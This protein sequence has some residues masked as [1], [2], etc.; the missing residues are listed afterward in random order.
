VQI[1]AAAVTSAVGTTFHQSQTSIQAVR[2]LGDAPCWGVQHSLEIFV[3]EPVCMH[4]CVRGNCT[5]TDTC[6]CE[7]GW[8]HSTVARDCAR[9]VCAA[10]PLPGCNDGCCNGGNCTAPSVCTCATGWSGAN[11]S[12]SVCEPLWDPAALANFD[13]E[14]GSACENGGVC[15]AHNTCNCSDAWSGAGCQI[16]VDECAETWLQTPPCSANSI[17]QDVLGSYSCT[18]REHFIGDGV[19]CHPEANFTVKIFSSKWDSV[20]IVPRVV[21]DVT[22]ALIIPNASVQVTG[23]TSSSAV[24]YVSMVF[25]LVPSEPWLTPSELTQRL[26]AAI[27]NSSAGVIG[28]NSLY[29]DRVYGVSVIASGASTTAMPHSIINLTL[30]AAWDP[31]LAIN[32]SAARVAFDIDF[33]TSM[34]KALAIDAERVHILSLMAGSIVV[35]WKIQESSAPAC[36]GAKM[37]TASALI[38]F[39]KLMSSCAVST[40]PVFGQYAAVSFTEQ[41]IVT[42]AE[43]TDGDT[44]SASPDIQCYSQEDARCNQTAACTTDADCVSLAGLADDASA[45][46]LNSFCEDGLGALKQGGQSAALLTAVPSVALLCTGC[47]LLVSLQT[48]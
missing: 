13:V 32:G 17:C 21:Q 35:T 46:C 22:T 24:T 5:L 28:P 27:V 36:A 42:A 12:V 3:S 11:C 19:W 10:V 45:F 23:V 1:F 33:H 7:A 8:D 6:T 41:H 43:A 44:F 39:R 31:Q 14:Q 34:S 47:L 38:G 9:P 15:V 40:C 4:N 48:R 16:N 29:F 26:M 30:S 20:A 18:C 2:Q 37:S 25:T